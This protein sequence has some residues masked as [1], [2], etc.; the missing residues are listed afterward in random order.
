MFFFKE[1]YIGLAIK[2]ANFNVKMS[3]K[4]LISGKIKGYVS[5]CVDFVLE[6]LEIS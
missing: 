3:Y 4:I 5:N 1:M 6:L 2:Y